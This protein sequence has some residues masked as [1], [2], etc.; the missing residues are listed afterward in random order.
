MVR[1]K[2]WVAGLAIVS[3]IL[4]SHDLRAVEPS[5]RRITLAE[6][7]QIALARNRT[8]QAVSFEK[9]AAEA[10]VGVAKAAM[11]PRVDAFETFSETDNPVLVF[12]DILLQ[13]SF[14]ERNFAIPSL[15]YPA[16]LSN[17]QSQLQL[18]LPVYAGGRLLAGLKAARFGAEAARWREIRA[19][20]QVTYAAV[21]AYYAAVLAENQL[22][23]VK[24]AL[25]AARSHLD[26]TRD[27]YAHGMVVQADELRTEVLAGSLEQQ[28]TTA[29]SRLRISWSALAH[30]LGDEDDFIAPVATLPP[31]FARMPAEKYS[32][33]SLTR[34]A[35]SNRPEL[36]VAAA[37]VGRAQQ[38]VKIALADYRPTINFATTVEDDSE[39]LVRGG[40]NFAFFAYARMNLFNGFAT[41]NRVAAARAQLRRAEALAEDVRR[42]IALEVE[43]AYRTLVAA[44]Q[45]V[46]VAQRNSRYASDALRILEDRYRSGLV[47]NVA[48]LDA[49]ATRQQADMQL[50]E[51]KVAVLIDR[52]SL[53]L[54]VGRHPA[55][56]GER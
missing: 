55:E 13:Q 30:T 12:S 18:S 45:N 38:A 1:S 53:D 22:E 2:V 42:A 27:L 11:M 23:V 29:Q 47:T 17:F 48:V 51:A 31:S 54:A 25:D 43:T 39:K 41:Q 10:E 52:A 24:R 40:N 21:Q 34:E 36:K 3:L 46:L 9:E 4:V 49:Q 7:I 5:P 32:L 15:N 16:P 33:E 14:S 28:M 56:I 6:A 37:N 20:D 35:E 8:L 44:E 50:V 19:R 26:V